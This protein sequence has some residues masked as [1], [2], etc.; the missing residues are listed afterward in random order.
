M[1]N[2]SKIH[3]RISNKRKTTVFL[4]LQCT[5]IKPL[6]LLKINMLQYKYHRFSKIVEKII[7]V[8]ISSV[9]NNTIT[10]SCY[11]LCH[12]SHRAGDRG[13]V[14]TAEVDFSKGGDV[15]DGQRELTKVVV[16]QVEAPQTR[17]PGNNRSKY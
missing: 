6:G 2:Q 15:A 16:G 7:T 12:G 13:Q 11:L 17:K 5:H 14:V 9:S 8:F 10:S 3:S 4:N 1:H